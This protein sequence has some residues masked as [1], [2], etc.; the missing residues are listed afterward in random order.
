M[1]STHYLSNTVMNEQD[2]KAEVIAEV[3]AFGIGSDSISDENSRLANY[4]NY[5][6]EGEDKGGILLIEKRWN[7]Y[8]LKER[9]LQLLGVEQKKKT[10]Y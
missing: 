1:T 2:V 4:V 9:I 5:E 6:N 8:F 10:R 3:S 7:L